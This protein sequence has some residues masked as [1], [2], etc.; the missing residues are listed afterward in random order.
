MKTSAADVLA[1]VFADLPHVMFCL[2][3]DEGRYVEANDA[4]IRRTGKRSR[5]QILGR[6]ATDLFPSALAL[7]YEAQDRAVFATGRP[8]RFQLETI[9]DGDGVEGWYLTNKVLLGMDATGGGD[10]AGARLLCVTSVEARLPRGTSPA[11]GGLRIALDY[12]RVHFSESLRI[13]DLASLAGMSLAQFERSVQRALGVTPK[14]FVQRLRCDAAATMLVT[15][16]RAIAEIADSCGFYDQSQFTRMFR[17]ATGM[18]PGV[19]RAAATAVTE[20]VD[21]SRLGR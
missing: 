17:V 19:Y 21:S 2:K 12:A 13:D 18:T 8:V 7:S 4:F 10:V 16:T 6:R 14:Q 20:V 3:D 9:T 15:T 1:S 11:S 5:R